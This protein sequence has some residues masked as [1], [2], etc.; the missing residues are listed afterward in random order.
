MIGNLAVSSLT[1]K[2]GGKITTLMGGSGSNGSKKNQKLVVPFSL[3]S[4]TASFQLPENHGESDSDDDEDI[5]NN[6]EDD[7]ISKASVVDDDIYDNLLSLMEDNEKN[8]R[9][10]ESVT[11]LLSQQVT[12]SNVSMLVEEIEQPDDVSVLVPVPVPVPGKS[13]KSKTRSVVH[14]KIKSKRT[15]KHPMNKNNKKH[16]TKHDTKHDQKPKKQVKKHDKKTTKKH[17]T[18]KRKKTRKAPGLFKSIQDIF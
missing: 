3:Y 11:A 4:S 9:E 5:G 16:D 7:D 2:K 14:G 15:K 12:P 18:K 8:N 13:L 17:E 6:D 10:L 1:N